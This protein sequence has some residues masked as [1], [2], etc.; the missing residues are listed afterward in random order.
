MTGGEIVIAAIGGVI[1]F[2]QGLTFFVL[3]DLRER[4]MRLETGE[5]NA[6]AGKRVHA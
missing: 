1:A 4:I 3:S 6:A 2:A 5:M